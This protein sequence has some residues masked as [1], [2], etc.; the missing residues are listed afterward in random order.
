TVSVYDAS[1]ALVVA[2][3]KVNKDP[4]SIAEYSGKV[5]IG[6]SS[7]NSYIYLFDL[8][9]Y[10]KLDSFF[11]ADGCFRDI[12]LDNSDNAYFIAGNF[13]NTTIKKL[14]INTG[15]ISDFMGPDP[16]GQ[17][18][19]GLAY[20]QIENKLYMSLAAS[21]FTSDGK[22]RVV[23]PNGSIEREFSTRV[24]PRRLLIK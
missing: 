15:A 23:N 24:G 13:G 9:S 17:I 5:L 7:T 19:Y 2:V 20:D 14:N 21:D 8:I 3:L 6:S 16:N 11:V 1:V 12:T 18:Y 10:N 4:S 22:F